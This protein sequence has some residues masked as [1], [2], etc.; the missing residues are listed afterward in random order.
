[1]RA[2]WQ[3]RPVSAWALYSVVRPALAS[4]RHGRG[5]ADNHSLSSVPSA[6]LFEMAPANHAERAPLSTR[7]LNSFWP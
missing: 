5:R 7:R 6:A 3:E 1:M 4:A 2:G